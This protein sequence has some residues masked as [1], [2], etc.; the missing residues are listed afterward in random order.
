MRNL[1]VIQ[2]GKFSENQDDKQ[3][4]KLENELLCGGKRKYLWMSH[5]MLYRAELLD[6]Y[7]KINIFP[8]FSGY[9]WFSLIYLQFNEEYINAAIVSTDNAI[10]S[11][12]EG[13]ESSRIQ[14]EMKQLEFNGC[15]H[16]AL[17]LSVTLLLCGVF[18]F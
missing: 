5:E 18:G 1:M 7:L 14:G 16:K 6:I 2:K 12:V 9:F 8:Y 17:N 3:L 11:T 10:Q 4:G 15:R 13:F